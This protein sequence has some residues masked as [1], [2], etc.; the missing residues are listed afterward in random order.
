LQALEEKEPDAHVIVVDDGLDWSRKQH[1]VP[2]DAIIP[3]IK[4]FVYARNVNLGIQAAPLKN[5]IV[6]LND[7]ALLKSTNG[8]GFM[9]D[10]SYGHDKFG[11]IGACSEATGNF[12]QLPGDYYL[13]EEPRMVC[14]V[15]VFIRRRVINCIGLLDECFTGYGFEDDD[16]C[17]RA[18]QSGFKIGISGGCFVDHKTLESTFRS[19]GRINLEPNR[20]RFVAKHGSHPL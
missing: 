2:V 17:L 4:P 9:S 1:N 20:L 12:R 8:L 18:R 7:D 16:Y 15:C 10:Q 19:H 6:L 11:I 3:G 13:R 5:D 14:F